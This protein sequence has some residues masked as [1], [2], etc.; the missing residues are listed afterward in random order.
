MTKVNSEINMVNVGGIYYPEDSIL[1]FIASCRAGGNTN[2]L[3][4]YD[5]IGSLRLM[6]DGRSVRKQQQV[7]PEVVADYLAKRRA[8][9]GGKRQPEPPPQPQL[10]LLPLHENPGR[11]DET[12][13][14]YDVTHFNIKV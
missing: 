12:S 7:S 6:P 4:D 14:P 10:Q 8:L 13:D 2:N 3:P 1:A 9:Y 11:R 5:E